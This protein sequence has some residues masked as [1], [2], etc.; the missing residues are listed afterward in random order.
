MNVFRQ[1][2]LWLGLSGAVAQA[3]HKARARLE[4]LLT[5]V[6]KDD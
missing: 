4:N 6:T 1:V 2:L 5:E 3:L